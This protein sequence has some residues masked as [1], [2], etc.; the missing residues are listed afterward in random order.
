MN[1]YIS[2]EFPVLLEKSVAEFAKVKEDLTRN[3]QDIVIMQ[4]NNLDNISIDA[5]K[6]IDVTCVV[7]LP[8]IDICP[9]VLSG[10]RLSKSVSMFEPFTSFPMIFP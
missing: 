6:N 5:G 9:L 8:N 7:K 3:W 2:N 4:N 10:A 1:N